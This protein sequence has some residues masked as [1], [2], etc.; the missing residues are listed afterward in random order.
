MNILINC[1]SSVSGGAVSYLRNLLPKLDALFQESN[2]GHGITILAHQEQKYLF[3]SIPDS[4]CILL[5]NSR[6]M[7][8]RRFLWEYRNLGKIV[9]SHNIDV[10]F[11]PY[12]ISPQ[13]NGVKQ[14]LMLRNMDPFCFGKYKYRFKPWLRNKVLFSQSQQS[15]CNADRV[16]AVSGYVEHTL[17]DRLN[18]SEDRIYRIYHGRD[19]N[20]SPN[21]DLKNDTAVLAEMNINGPYIL[22]CGSL[23]PYRRCEDVI[24]A[25]DLHREKTGQDVNLIIAGSKTYG[26]YRKLIERLILQSPNSARIHAIGLVSYQA[27]QAIYRRCVFCVLATEVE[28]CPNIA[29]EAMSSGCAVISSDS[30]PLPEIF[31][32]S[33]LEFA[34][35]NIEELT[36]KMKE[37]VNNERLI[38]DIKNKAL[39]R[40]KSFSWDECAKRTYHVLVQ[41]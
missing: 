33:S 8:C 26:P 18:I 37:L 38:T 3:P 7:G 36:S 19:E 1:L 31:A 10:L 32:D 16:I 15:L 5:K 28:A 40:A 25:F 2:Q 11:T 27:M 34:S 21:G 12:Q 4:N 39:E 22:T 24:R 9:S 23:W 35:R 41:W 30:P 14:V 20:F 29:I 17:V 13:I 6:P